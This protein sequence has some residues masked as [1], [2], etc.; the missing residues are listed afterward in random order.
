M[1]LD[2]DTSLR[3]AVEV[4]RVHGLKHIVVHR[5]DEVNNAMPCHRRTAGCDTRKPATPYTMN[6]AEERKTKKGKKI[7]H[8]RKKDVYSAYAKKKKRRTTKQRAEASYPEY[9]ARWTCNE[10]REGGAGMIYTPRKGK[11]M[12]GNIHPNNHPPLLPYV[13]NM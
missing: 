13:R 3:K 7:C 12:L 10:E 9:V 1:K 4:L 5:G 11:K 2:S 8:G 6:I